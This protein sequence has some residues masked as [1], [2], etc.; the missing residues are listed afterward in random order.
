MN[1]RFTE[2]QSCSG[3][4]DTT[5]Q[6]STQKPEGSSETTTTPVDMQPTGEVNKRLDLIRQ[7]RQVQ[8]QELKSKRGSVEKLTYLLKQYALLWERLKDEDRIT[9]ED[10]LR[11]TSQRI[12]KDAQ[13]VYHL[14][15]MGIEND[16]LSSN[17]DT[18]TEMPSETPSDGAMI[19]KN[20][21][22]KNELSQILDN[23]RECVHSTSVYEE[24]DKMA[25]DIMT[26]VLDEAAKEVDIQRSAV[27]SYRGRGR[28]SYRGRGRGRGTKIP[29]PD[30]SKY[31][32]DLRPNVIYIKNLE[33]ISENDVREALKDYPGV[34]G[35]TVNENE[36]K[37]IFEQHWQTNKPIKGGITIHDK[38]SID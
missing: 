19:D 35:V 11:N 8:L 17:D 5:N 7:K 33:N 25:T 20:E 21:K 15:K 1:D 30:V 26:S 4:I 38:V 27:P 31:Q 3:Q 2:V 36:A 12:F 9:H 18:T 28:G 24:I 37:V 29:R 23:V 14:V 32:I 34:R 16:N 22:A 10:R 6:P 13:D